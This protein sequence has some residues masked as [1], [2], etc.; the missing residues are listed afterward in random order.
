[1]LTYTVDLNLSN[2]TGQV[3]R[4]KAYKH[5]RIVNRTAH[6]AGIHTN[7]STL[8]DDYLDC[9]DAPDDPDNPRDTNLD[10]QYGYSNIH[11]PDT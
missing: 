7:A 11:W 3:N 2:E 4:R 6:Q 10:Q 8:I 9:I 1:M 5:H